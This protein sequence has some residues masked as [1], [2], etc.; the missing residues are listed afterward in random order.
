[1][2]GRRLHLLLPVLLLLAGVA[3]PTR[4]DLEL[5]FLSGRVVDQADLLPPAAEASLTSKLAALEAETGAQVVV[6][7]VATLGDEPVEDL[8]VRVAE[9]WQLG[10]EGVDDGVLFVI[11]REERALRIE[12]GYGLEPKLTDITSKRILDELVVPRFRDG[13]FAGGVDAG[14]DAIATA[15]RG[16]EPLP[17]PSPSS[18]EGLVDLPLAARGGILVGFAAVLLPFLLAA[19]FTPGASGWF[20]WLFMLPFLTVFPFAAFGRNGLVLAALWVLVAAPLRLWLQLTGR[21]KRLSKR[22]SR[23]WQTGG[24]GWS[25]G[26]GSGGGWRGGGSGGGFRGGGGFSGGGGS[27]GGGGASSRW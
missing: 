15:V 8:A 27:F 9:G 20:L 21:G 6:L 12:V 7:T 3:T 2:T 14:V 26:S 25:A 1:M 16:G 13:D 18:G 5:P 11:A 4:A 24:G 10:R 23:W 22:Q 17:P 19:L